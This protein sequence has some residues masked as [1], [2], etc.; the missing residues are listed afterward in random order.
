MKK[1]MFVGLIS[2]FTSVQ[3]AH[4]FISTD[5]PILLKMLLNNVS[6]LTQLVLLV[7]RST[8][9]VRMMRDLHSGIHEALKVHKKLKFEPQGD[10]YEKWKTTGDALTKI[11][12]MYGQLKNDQRS[13]K[14]LGDSDRALAEALSQRSHALKMVETSSEIAA[15]L[16]RV[17]NLS[18][19]KG[20]A[21]LTAQ[22][23]G[24]L[25]DVS[26]ETLR[27]QNE[28]LKLQATNMLKENSEDKA[29]N[30]H[31]IEVSDE[32]KRLMASS[33]TKFSRPRL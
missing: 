17:A 4:A 11:Q 21:R 3:S 10:L 7:E 28:S 33:K 23:V 30:N 14:R 6:Q 18:S 19:Q 1:F 24:S 20:A 2:L 12:S 32:M 9:Q 29:R 5:A 8:D 27:T 31:L 26:S 16:K 13:L 22:G 15:D 25:I